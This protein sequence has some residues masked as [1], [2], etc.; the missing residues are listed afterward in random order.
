MFKILLLFSF[1]SAIYTNSN[2]K[3]IVGNR[4]AGNFNQI[5][6]KWYY[7]YNDNNGSQNQRF[8][9]YNITYIP[10]IFSPIDYLIPSKKYDKVLGFNEP[11]IGYNGSFR[12]PL[13]LSPNQTLMHWGIIDNYNASYVISP[14]VLQG[15]LFQWMPS[16]LAGNGTYKPKIDALALHWYGDNIYKF[17][18]YIDSAWNTFGL[19]IW[20]TEFSKRDKVINYKYNAPCIESVNNTISMEKFVRIAIKEMENRTYI[21]GYAWY[22]D[23]DMPF[24]SCYSLWDKNKNLTKL[25]KIYAGII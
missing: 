23:L 20:V 19:P 13:S 1:F 6:A 2:K 11:D 8:H 9:S 4:F 18:K 25:G 16:F 10:M 22:S 24:L 3:G 15:N 7:A 12:K 5:N 17:L 21:K 14:A